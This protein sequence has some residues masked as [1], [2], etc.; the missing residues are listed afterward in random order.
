MH[1]PDWYKNW[2]PEGDGPAVIHSPR[3]AE[4]QAAIWLRRLGYPDAEV[5]PAG[6]DFGVDV[7][8]VGA[9][10]Q[11]KHW[12]KNAPLEA[13]Q[14]IAGSAIRGQKSF[15]FSTS[16]YTKAALT[17]ASQEEVE[18]ALF[19]LRLD[20]RIRAV[21]KPSILALEEAPYRGENRHPSKREAYLILILTF[22]T[23]IDAFAFVGFSIWMWMYSFTHGFSGEDIVILLAMFTFLGVAMPLACHEVYKLLVRPRFRYSEKTAWRRLFDN[24]PLYQPAQLRD[25]DSVPYRF[26]GILPVLRSTRPRRPI[27]NYLTDLKTRRVAKRLQDRKPHNCPH[28]SAPHT[29]YLKPGRSSCGCMT[30]MVYGDFDRFTMPR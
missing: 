4:E 11:V 6:Q 9:V 28:G 5:T 8:A 26:S 17:W 24:V 25:L 10:A 22:F 21:N 13:V 12:K 27:R 20:G 16:G 15:F 7:Y 2:L 1:Q 30:G 19:Q 18:T 3:Q 23:F 14:R 29:R